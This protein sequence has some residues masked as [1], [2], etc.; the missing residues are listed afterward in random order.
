MDPQS[1]FRSMVHNF[2]DVEIDVGGVVDYVPKVDTKIHRIKE[3]Y[4]A[5]KSGLP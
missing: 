3:I 2:P 4:R 1:T 5:I